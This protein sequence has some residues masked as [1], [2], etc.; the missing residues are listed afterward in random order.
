MRINDIISIFKSQIFQKKQVK[1]S[2]ERAISVKD[3]VTISK[4]GKTLQKDK[5][6]FLVAKKA[7]SQSPKIGQEKIQSALTKIENNFYD[8][9]TVKEKLSEKI[10]TSGRFNTEIF[11]ARIASKYKAE[12]KKVPDLRKEKISE[13]RE[14]IRNKFYN[15]KKTISELSER[16]LKDLGI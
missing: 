12:L 16:I 10:L 14:K 8:K 4:K 15:N 13:I 2:K 9:S 7:L 3:T 6:E 11:S 1:T 5:A